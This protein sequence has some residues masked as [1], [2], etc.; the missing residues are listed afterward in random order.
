MGKVGAFTSGGFSGLGSSFVAAW[1]EY[2]R[3]FAAAVERGPLWATQFHPEKSGAVGLAL[4]AN[5]VEAAAA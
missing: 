3:E 5:F 4:L 1:C 2:G